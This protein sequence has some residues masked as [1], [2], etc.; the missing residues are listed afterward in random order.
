MTTGYF[1]KSAIAFAEDKPIE[2][3]DGEQLDALL[4]RHGV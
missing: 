1:T 3:I 4:K 2:L